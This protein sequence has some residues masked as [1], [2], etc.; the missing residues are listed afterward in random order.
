MREEMMR[1][2]GLLVDHSTIYLVLLQ[3]QT[4]AIAKYKSCVLA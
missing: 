4:Q 3:K 2:R 1:E